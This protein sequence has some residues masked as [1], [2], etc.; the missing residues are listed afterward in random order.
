MK[1]IPWFWVVTVLFWILVIASVLTTA[2][3]HRYFDDTTP[4]NLSV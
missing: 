4:T 1:K 3:T 2:V